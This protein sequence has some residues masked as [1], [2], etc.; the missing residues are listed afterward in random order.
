MRLD[1]PTQDGSMQ[2]STKKIHKVIAS[3]YNTLGAQYGDSLTNLKNIT[4]PDDAALYTGDRDLP[5]DGGLS[6]DDDIF[7]SGDGCYPC[8]V[9]AL[10]VHMEKTGE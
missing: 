8:T 1:V 5:F 6:A 4:W 3:F 10:I 7:I 9:R 2:G